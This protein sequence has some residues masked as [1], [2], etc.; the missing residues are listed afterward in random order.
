MSADKHR[1]VFGRSRS[2]LML[3]RWPF[4]IRSPCWRKQRAAAAYAPSITRPASACAALPVA[5]V[6]FGLPGVPGSISLGGRGRPW[7]FRRQPPATRQGEDTKRGFAA[8]AP[9]KA[10][11][12]RLAAQHDALARAGH[13]E[14]PTRDAGSWRPEPTGR[15]SR[16]APTLCEE[17]G[18]GVQLRMPGAADC[19]RRGSRRSCPAS[20]RTPSRS[21]RVRPR[22]GGERSPSQSPG[23]C[24]GLAVSHRVV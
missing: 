3:T 19:L 20:A 11:L 24:R 5:L 16:R 12:R 17:R 18:S 13:A 7:A 14:R 9:P 22:A 23:C 10:S 6:I 8:H 21:R 4:V 2:D 1:W 15:G